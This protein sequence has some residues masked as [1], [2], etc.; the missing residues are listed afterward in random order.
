[1]MRGKAKTP[2]E[3]ESKTQVSNPKAFWGQIKKL[4][5][6]S[7][8]KAPT[9][10][11]TWLGCY[12]NLLNRIPVSVN[13]SLHRFVQNYIKSHDKNCLLCE[14]GNFEGYD[15]LMNRDINDS[16]V[17]THIGKVKNGKAHGVDEILNEAIK[18]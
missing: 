16:E 12:R 7:V 11:K 17:K 14:T 10:A 4:S 18:V 9:D 15:S 2:R 13:K 1:M 8:T 3:V 6:T 5:F